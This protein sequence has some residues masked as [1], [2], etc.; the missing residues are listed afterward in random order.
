M[1][2]ERGDR[3]VLFF[4]ARRLDEHLVAVNQQWVVR[5]ADILD[6]MDWG[7]FEASYKPGG[8]PPLHPARVVGL[9]IYGAMLGQT[10]LRQ[11]EALAARDL[12]ALWMTAGLIPD[13]T[14][15]MRFM[16]RHR[17]LLSE[18]FFTKTAWLITK[19]LKLK[20]GDV[21]LDGTIV[22][23]VSSTAKALKRDTLDDVLAEAKAAGETARVEK[24]EAASEQLEKRQ[25]VRDE[26]GKPGT[27]VVSPDEPEAVLQPQKNSRD[28][29][30]SYKP[31]FATHESGV[32]V[33]QAL[34]PSSETAC[35]SSLLRQH[36]AVF[37]DNPQRVLADSAFNTV[38]LLA[39]FVDEGVDALIPSGRGGDSRRR[40]DGL[41]APADF[42]VSDAG[43]PVCPAGT[44]MKRSGNGTDVGGRHFT[45]FRGVGC[46]TC[47]LKARCTSAKARTFKLFDG[48]EVKRAMDSVMQ[49]PAAR[50]AYRRRAPIAETTFARLQ[51]LGLL[52]FR[53]RGVA[54]ARLELAIA[55]T[56]LNFR[57]FLWRTADVFVVFLAARVHGAWCG[58][59]TIGTVG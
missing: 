37:G 55:A 46:P 3:S 50:L 27:A 29:R 48:Y 7:G 12:G 33:G 58:C 13:F 14:T 18:D 26:A 52:R 36:E 1:R 34:S 47:P 40:K 51:R 32:I 59:V 10:S 49:H 54:G 56:A 35:V 9:I 16:Q 38:A 25:R 23:A 42:S 6:G 24:L 31:V 30:L 44:E 43:L 41:F 53:R 45:N 5:L 20:R 22:Q 21:A 15:L 17:V 28:F 11:M 39:R 2:F 19:R 4:G 57:L 8:R